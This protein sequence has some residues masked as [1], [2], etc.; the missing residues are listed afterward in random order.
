MPPAAV[1]ESVTSIAIQMP[2]DSPVP[3]IAS[4]TSPSA[5]KFA[6]M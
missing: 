4:M 5:K 3:N 1:Y 6:A 2:S